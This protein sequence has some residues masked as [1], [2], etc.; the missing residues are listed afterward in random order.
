MAGRN[1]TGNGAFQLDGEV[2]DAAARVQLERRGDGGGGAGGEAARAFAA[3]ILLRRVRLQFERRDDFREKNPVAE[4]AADEVGVLADE[5]ETGAL[6]EVAFQQRAGVHIPERAR[7]PAPPSW[8]T[9]C[10]QFLSRSP[11]TSW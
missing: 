2:G 9:K 3:M 5:A 8:S 10:D 1:S 6:R 7:S 11:R 4:S